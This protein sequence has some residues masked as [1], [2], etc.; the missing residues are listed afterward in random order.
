MSIPPLRMDRKMLMKT[1]YPS[2][3]I[4]DPYNPNYM[5]VGSGS[6][7]PGFSFSTLKADRAFDS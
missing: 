6:L 7:A 3:K 2:P 1:N 5:I 4:R